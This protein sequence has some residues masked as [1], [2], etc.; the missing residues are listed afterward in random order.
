M[1]RACSWPAVLVLGG[2]LIGCGAEAIEPPAADESRQFRNVSDSTVAFVGDAACASCHEAEYRGY[3]AHGMARSFYPLTPETAVEDFSGVEVLHEPT[4]LR[5]RAYR[6][7]DR[8]FQEEYRLDAAGRRV[9]ALVREMLYVVGSGTAAR[10]YL[11][12]SNGH[13]YELPLTWYTQPRKWDFSPGY[14]EDN[15]R[16]DR[17]VP[18]RCMTCHN[19]Y[20]AGVPYVEGKYTQVPLGIGC[21][22]CHGPGALHVETQLASA[23]TGDGFDE[24]IVNPKHLSLDRRLDVCQQCHLSGTVMLLRAGRTAY[25]FRPSQDLAGYVALFSSDQA[26]ADGQ[27][28]VISHAD[29]MRQSVC[30]TATQGQPAAM[31]CITC[32]NPH[33]GFRDKGPGYFN[34]TCLGCHDAGLLAGQVAPAARPDHTGEANCIA[35]HM[36]RVASEAPH[37]SFTD[38]WIRVVVPEA[39]KPVAA[40]QPVILH[41]YFDRDRRGAAA[42]VMTGM[43]YVVYGTQFRDRQALQTGI[44]HLEQALAQQPDAGEA[45]YLLGYARMQLG[46]WQAAI[47]A[48]EAA[49][50]LD[51]RIPERLNALAQAYEATG[52]D[53]ARTGQAY[54]Q[55]LQRQPALAGVRVNY[56]RFL[57]TQGRLEEALAQYQRAAADQPWLAPAQYNLGTAQLRKG[58]TRPAEAAL[59]QALSLHPDHVEA[60]GNLGLLYA[61][62]GRS[63]EARA[64]FERAV[65][66]APQNA[67]ALANLGTWHLQAGDFARAIDLLTRAVAVNPAALDALVNLAVAH[68]QQGDREQARLYARQVL[69]QHPNHPTARQLLNALP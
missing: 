50:R 39:P 40:H 62:A 47:P 27:I 49:V 41:P 5:Y 23:D 32:H 7:G 51:N 61:A 26:E 4:G 33:E 15:P 67:V 36:P 21:E 68:F 9:H 46:Q 31:E 29:R 14:R 60:L 55:A 48:L 30:F 6:E 69:Q 12:E 2:L 52:G 8:F 66:V 24:T 20:P 11:A 63:A 17:L 35:C 38:H 10:T 65:Q 22:R 25:D 34:R 54:E 64:L 3:Q 59:R 58:Q 43:A 1:K 13:L 45:H 42:A 44:G 16:F 18:D 56:G 57:E 19:S 53:P 37:S 28:G